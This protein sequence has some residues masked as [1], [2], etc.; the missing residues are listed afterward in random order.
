MNVKQRLI[1]D[2]ALLEAVTAHKAGKLEKADQIY[3]AILEKHPKHPGTSHNI[4]VLAV[5]ICKVKEA[6]PF[7]KTAL[8]TNPSNPQFWVSYI[9]A[10]KN[11]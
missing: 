3:T 11:S 2:Q 8:E 9:G 10:L 7:L 5:G 6:L 1:L 4:G